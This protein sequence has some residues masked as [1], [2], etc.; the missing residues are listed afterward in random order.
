MT[1]RLSRALVRARIGDMVP[2]LAALQ[3]VAVRVQSLSGMALAVRDVHPRHPLHLF[4]LEQ[5]LAAT[6]AS[7]SPTRAAGAVLLAR[8]AYFPGD[9]QGGDRLVTERLCALLQDP[10]PEVLIAAATGL[11]QRAT[12]RE[13]PA[14]TRALGRADAP[15]VRVA[16]ITALG[17]AG[18]PGAIPTIAAALREPAQ[19]V[20]RAAVQALHDC[21]TPCESSGLREAQAAENDPGLR[22]YMRSVADSL[23][24]QPRHFGI[25]D[26]AALLGRAPEPGLERRT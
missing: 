8:L 15:E 25:A 16:I 20:R 19:E 24:S 9:Q 10:A 1:E 4:A 7:D 22:E 18:T 13:V 21:G 26:L 12:H 2:L 6:E 5:A 3:D 17:Q 14:L 23:D 11:G